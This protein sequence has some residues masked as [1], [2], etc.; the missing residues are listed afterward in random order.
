MEISVVGK[1]FVVSAFDSFVW[2]PQTI[3]KKNIGSIISALKHRNL[4]S[5]FVWKIIANL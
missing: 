3:A 1:P 2:E 5:H 4:N